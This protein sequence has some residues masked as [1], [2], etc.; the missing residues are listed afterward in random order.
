[1]NKRKL[2][3]IWGLTEEQ[4]EYCEQNNICAVAK[5]FSG[6]Y[7]YALKYYSRKELIKAYIEA[8]FY[9]VFKGY[10]YSFSEVKK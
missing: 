1:M 2:Y 8:W 10:N 6:Q 4:F 7:E 9:N 3:R 5:N